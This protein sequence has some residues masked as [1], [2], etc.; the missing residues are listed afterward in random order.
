MKCIN[1]N[2]S[3]SWEQRRMKE[4]QIKVKREAKIYGFVGDA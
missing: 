4:E 3:R 1:N 2:S